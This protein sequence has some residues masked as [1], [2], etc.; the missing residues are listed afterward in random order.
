[1]I[2]SKHYDRILIQARFFQSIQDLSYFS[3]DRLGELVVGIEVT[4]PFF[5][6]KFMVGKMGFQAVFFMI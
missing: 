4:S 5:F 6:P 3:I 2:G 1:M